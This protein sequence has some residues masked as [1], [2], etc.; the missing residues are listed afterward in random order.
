MSLIVRLNGPWQLWKIWLSSTRTSRL[1]SLI[2]RDVAQSRMYLLLSRS[3]THMLIAQDLV[4]FENAIAD[5]ATRTAE[6]ATARG[7]GSLMVFPSVNPYTDR[8]IISVL[9]MMGYA[10]D[11]FF[12]SR[13]LIAASSDTRI[14]YNKISNLR[15]TANGH[16]YSP[17]SIE[18][19]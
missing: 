7:L 14:L 15:L 11:K 8:T 19:V 9:N 13:R 16:S 5:L 2:I 3:R 12:L 4:F 6:Q 10:H 18:M 1:T 17:G